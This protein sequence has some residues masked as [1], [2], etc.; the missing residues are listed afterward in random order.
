MR[1]TRK[2]VKEMAVRSTWKGAISCGPMNIPCKLY[3]ATEEKTLHFNQLHSCGK[4]NACFSMMKK[5]D[6][7]MLSTKDLTLRVISDSLRIIF[8]AVSKADWAKAQKFTNYLLES[9][10]WLVEHK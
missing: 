7:A 2:E 3:A 4:A 5:G 8:E 6:N 1:Q 10:N 9:L